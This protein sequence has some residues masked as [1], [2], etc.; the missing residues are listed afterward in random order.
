[1]REIEENLRLN[2]LCRWNDLV[3]SDLALRPLR[4]RELL[5]LS[6]TQAKELRQ[7]PHRA[8]GSTL[9]AVCLLGQRLICVQ[10]GDG[11][12]FLLKDGAMLP[13]FSDEEEP[14]ANLTYSLC[15][16]DAF[17]HLHVKIFDFRHLDGVLLCTDG[18]LSP[19]Q[20][21]ENF[22][23]SFVRPTVRSLLD[24]ESREVRDF[25]QLLGRERGCGDDVSLSVLVKHTANR[26]RYE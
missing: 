23:R 13:A 3:S 26:R 8:Y 15:N 25:V 19:Y 2:I 11:G 5:A 10:L 14:V 7:S 6:A 9:T 20:S 12:C 24:G 4:R 16:E 18:V 21:F 22:N 17:D 1:V